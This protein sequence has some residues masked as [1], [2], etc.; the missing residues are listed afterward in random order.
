M[1]PATVNWGSL[2][3]PSRSG[4]PKLKVARCWTPSGYRRAWLTVAPVDSQGRI[5]R[6]HRHQGQVSL[7]L[8]RELD[9]LR[10]IRIQILDLSLQID[11]ARNVSA[12]LDTQAVQQHRTQY[13]YL[14]D[15]GF[16][17]RPLGLELADERRLKVSHVALRGTAA[18]R[19]GHGTDS[20]RGA[21][22]H[23]S[24]AFASGSTNSSR[25]FSAQ[26]LSFAPWATGR[27]SP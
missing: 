19:H 4:Q 16:P 18:N 2:A 6:L 24:I 21:N 20:N 15:Q 12:L 10:E 25:R 27:S 9:E 8:S 7:S 26:A 22:L 17:L 5:H 1:W 11:P 13:L 23:F 3:I 14:R